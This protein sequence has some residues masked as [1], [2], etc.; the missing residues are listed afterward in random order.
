MGKRIITQRR[1]RGTFT[2]KAHSHRSPGALTHHTFDQKEK[3][4]VVTGTVKALI[5][6]RAHSA[7]LAH[8]QF[9]DK[10]NVLMPAPLGM[11]EGATLQSGLKAELKPGN[12]L[13]LKQIPEGTDIYNI[14]S[15]V[16]DGGKFA[17]S[18]G[19]TAKVLAQRGPITLIQLPS[20]KEREFNAECRATIGIVAGGGRKEKPF[21]KAG[22]RHHA[23]RGRGKLYPQT[24]GVA[25]NAV[26]H[27]FGS[28]RGRHVGKPKVPP[29]FAPPGRNI[30][31]LHARRTGRK[32]R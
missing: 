1:G 18:S 11:R 32:K 17:R 23:M 29:R 2:Y 19:T 10:E 25:M 20:K 30:G 5:H 7:P 13:P 6:S 31:L 14:E 9:E 22:K 28:G 24:S 3:T 27:P 16:G 26:D 15:S 21:V 12:T 4:E 8:V